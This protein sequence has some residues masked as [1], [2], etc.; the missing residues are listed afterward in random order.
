MLIPSYGSYRHG[1]A[2]SPA[3][4]VC[5]FCFDVGLLEAETNHQLIHLAHVTLCFNRWLHSLT[6]TF[7]VG[8]RGIF[9]LGKLLSGPFKF[10]A[11]IPCR[12]RV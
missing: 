4:C 2:C 9:G 5:R 10:T 12:P 1:P 6:Q 11:S 8:E 3:R 7:F